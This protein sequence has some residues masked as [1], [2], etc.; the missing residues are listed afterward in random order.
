MLNSLLFR[1]SLLWLACRW[2]P[3]R[4]FNRMF[5]EAMEMASFDLVLNDMVKQIEDAFE[6]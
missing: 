3:E 6:E 1:A 5:L 4:E 2:N